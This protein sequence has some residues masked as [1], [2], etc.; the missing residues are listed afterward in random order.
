MQS[1]LRYPGG[2]TKRKVRSLILSHAPHGYQEYREP[3]VG[4]GGVFFSIGDDHK[5]WINDLNE[6][7]VDVY[8][9]LR[10]RPDEF[11]KRCKSVQPRQ[12]GEPDVYPTANSSGKKY[13][14]RL[15]EQF[16]DL[17]FNNDE[18]QAFRYFF[19]NRT[20][21][22]GRVDYERKSRLY[23][24]NPEGWDIV[25]T[26]RIEAAAEH[27]R[28]VKVTCGDYE[29]L[30]LAPGKNVW[31]YCDPPYMRD[32]KLSATDKLYAHGFTMQDHERFAYLAR[33]SEHK[34]C[35]SYDDDPKVRQLFKGFTIIP[36]QWVYCG[37]SNEEKKIG[38]E[39]LILNYPVPAGAIKTKHKPKK[40]A[41]Y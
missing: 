14:K 26:Q 41:Q 36:Q 31:V 28:N 20:V 23:F 13:N 38:Q 16:D 37:T 21:W 6:G 15:K 9:A 18:D 8:L 39:L 17:K 24:S 30:L 25:A 1:I 34:L 19:I 11:I 22:A 12:P 32:T 3:F 4:G 10:D 29:N 2:K 7:L 27:L 5:R 33:K 40:M 35:I